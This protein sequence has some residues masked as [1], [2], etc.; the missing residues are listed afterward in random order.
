MERRKSVDALIATVAKEDAEEDRG[1]A[2]GGR[3]KKRTNCF[4][5]PETPRPK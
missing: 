2:E 1:Q 4:Y 5:T 3:K